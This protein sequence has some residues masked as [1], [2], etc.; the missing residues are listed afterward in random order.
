MISWPIVGHE[1]ATRMLQDAVMR[2]ETSHAMLIT[3]PESVGKMTLARV[4]SKAFLCKV[5]PEQRPCGQCISCR[6]ME[7]GNHPDFM[8]VEPDEGK[9]IVTIDKIRGVERFLLLTPLESEFKVALISS[10]EKANFYAANALLKTLE[11]PPTH[12]KLI[13]LATDPDL[14]LPTIVSRSQQ[15]NLRPVTADKIATALVKLWGLHPDEAEQL[16]RIAGGR[17][18]WA[19]RAATNP[20]VRAAMDN[21]LSLLFDVMHQDLVSR[22]ETAGTL[23]RQTDNLVEVLE[24]WLTCWRDVLLLHTG[25]AAEIIFREKEDALL[26]IAEFSNLH[27]TTRII[28]FV[29]DAIT[30]LQKNT[31][32][33]LLIENVVLTFPELPSEEY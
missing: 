32:T 20:E 8:L 1:W 3:G 12:G 14:L 18:G 33:L 15:V 28:N 9:T 11:E 17:V 5:E 10:F 25:N 30:A 31:N 24:I 27:Q 26:E 23:A 19:M 29:E 2:N 21:A 22:F 4:L 7:S 13:L 6:K 16:A